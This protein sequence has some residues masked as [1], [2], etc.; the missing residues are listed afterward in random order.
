MHILAPN[1][2]LV[3]PRERRPHLDDAQLLPLLQVRVPV[4][5]VLVRGTTPE[6]EQRLCDVPA[7]LLLHRTL[8]QEAAHRREPGPRGEHDHRDTGVLWR[9][10]PRC[11]RADGELDDV[12]WAEPRE[13][14]RRNAEERL[15]LARQSGRLD[16]A[17]RQRRSLR[18]VEGRRRDGV[19]PDAHRGEHLEVGAERELEVCVRLENVKDAD[20]FSEDL[21]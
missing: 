8:L 19:L 20:T 21:L 2:V 5:E 7:R 18:V 12:A 6:E 11:R 1:R 10:E 3:A 16:D 9:V 4:Q 15:R 14:V 17:N 13:E